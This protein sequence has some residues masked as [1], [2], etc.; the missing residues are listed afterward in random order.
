M[1]GAILVT[2]DLGGAVASHVRVSATWFNIVFPV[3]IG[4]LD[5]WAVSGCTTSA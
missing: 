2:G 4:V 1:P 3:A 5:V